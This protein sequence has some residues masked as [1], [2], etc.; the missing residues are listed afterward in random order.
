MAMSE[1]EKL[2]RPVR[3]LEDIAA[4]YEAHSPLPDGSRGRWV[5]PTPMMTTSLRLPVPLVDAL[6][7]EAKRT[8][9]RYTTLVRGL[10]EDHV[11]YSGDSPQLRDIRTRLT[12]VEAKL[13]LSS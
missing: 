3:E 4:Y 12:R 2:P 9:I 8:G 6:K 7:G 13:E 10:L 1:Q 5:D 11:N